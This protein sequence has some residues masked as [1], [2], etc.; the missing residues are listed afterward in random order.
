MSIDI[1]VGGSDRLKAVY[2]D[3]AGNV[4]TV[5][6]VGATTLAWTMDTPDVV[7]LDTAVGAI[8]NATDVGASGTST[9]LSVTDGILTSTPVAIAIVAGP[10]VTLSIEPDTD[11]A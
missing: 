6:P 8:V 10:A 9:N 2:R 5:P 11:P 3:A 4:T 7:S 1:P